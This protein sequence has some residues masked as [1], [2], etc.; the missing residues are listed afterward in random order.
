MSLDRIEESMRN[1]EALKDYPRLLR[2]RNESMDA[3]AKQGKQLEDQHKV[4]EDQAKVIEQ[5]SRKIEDSQKETKEL[6]GAHEQLK[7]SYETSEANK[8]KLTIRVNELESQRT[9]A[10]GKTLPEI[11]TIMLEREKAAIETRANELYEQHKT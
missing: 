2:E 10:E 11:E 9:S 1:I 3:I 5:Q 6:R 7:I 8:D 4:I